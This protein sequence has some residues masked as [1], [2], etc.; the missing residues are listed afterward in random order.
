MQP[1]IDDIVVTWIERLEKQW[2]SSIPGRARD[3]DIGKRIQFL[4]V[5]ITTKLCLGESF[6]CIEE[7]R[8]QYAF[9]ET[10]KNATPISLQLSLF[11]ELTKMMYH[12]TKL[13]P[14]H[15]LLVPSA[16]DRGGIG[17]VM[18]VCSARQAIPCVVTDRSQVI[19]NAINKRDRPE[20]VPQD[21]LESFLS[22]GLSREQAETELVVSLWV[23][24]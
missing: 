10:V 23:M 17:N 6:R 12:L 2:S 3:F 24:T 22:R 4:A 14:I 1:A 20:E 8:D 18:G 9:L 16:K 19:R 11:P 5:D 7:D 21:M 15:R 13:S